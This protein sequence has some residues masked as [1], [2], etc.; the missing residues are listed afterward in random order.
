MTMVAVRAI[1]AVASTLAVGGSIQAFR[2]RGRPFAAGGPAMRPTATT[3]SPGLD[4]RRS[5]VSVACPAKA[6][7]AAAA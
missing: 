4:G 6:P 7:R 5:W 2:V 1:S 3:G